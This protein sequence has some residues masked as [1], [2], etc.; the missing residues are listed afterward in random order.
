MHGVGGWMLGSSNWAGASES[1]LPL[2]HRGLAVQALTFAFL[3]WVDFQ[4]GLLS[5]SV[6]LPAKAASSLEETDSQRGG[7]GLGG[8]AQRIISPGLYLLLGSVYERQETFSFW[9]SQS[10]WSLARLYSSGRQWS[11]L[12]SLLQLGWVERG[13]N[14]VQRRRV[15]VFR[16]WAASGLCQRKLGAVGLAM[17]L[18]SSILCFS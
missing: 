9:S 2:G 4:I 10:Y 3:A 17:V 6:M 11:S 14:A 7:R 8:T 12:P 1:C 15:N 13:E 16:H 18:L 5:P